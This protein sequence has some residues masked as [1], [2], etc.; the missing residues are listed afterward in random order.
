MPKFRVEVPMLVWYEC[1]IEAKT[2]KEAFEKTI[3]GSRFDLDV[4]EANYDS[5]EISPEEHSWHVHR[6]DEDGEEGNGEPKFFSKT[7]KEEKSKKK[8][9]K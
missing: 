9:G 6:L 3:L 5:E 2:F 8:G 1:E 4:H 7:P